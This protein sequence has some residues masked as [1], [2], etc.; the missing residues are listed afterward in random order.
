MS[1]PYIFL[2]IFR[3][4][5]LDEDLYL[6]KFRFNQVFHDYQA[7]MFLKQMLNNPTVRNSIPVLAALGDV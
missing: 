1:I 4:I 3:G 5:K 6:R 7:D 2:A